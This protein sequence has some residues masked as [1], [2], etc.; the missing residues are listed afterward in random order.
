MSNFILINFNLTVYIIFAAQKILG[1]CSSNKRILSM[2][3]SCH[4]CL[5]SCTIFLH[6]TYSYNLDVDYCTEIVISGYWVGPD[7]DDGWGFVE[8]VINQM[9]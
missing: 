7:A 9:N 8:A 3:G 4:R 2:K 1:T 5:M 6:E